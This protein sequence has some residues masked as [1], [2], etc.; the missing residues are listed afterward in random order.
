ML[1]VY[2]NGFKFACKPSVTYKGNKKSL[3][4]L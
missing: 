2:K 4:H 3:K 1:V